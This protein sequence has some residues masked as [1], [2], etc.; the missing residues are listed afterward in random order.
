M[1][2]LYYLYKFLKQYSLQRK[3]VLASFFA[4]SALNAV[5]PL[6]GLPQ[7]LKGSL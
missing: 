2:M 6:H 1:F 4:K 3:K 5:G 7:G